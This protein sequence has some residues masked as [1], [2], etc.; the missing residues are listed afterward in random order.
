VEEAVVLQIVVR[1]I[2]VQQ[3][4]VPQIVVAR[5]FLLQTVVARSLSLTSWF[6]LGRQGQKIGTLMNPVYG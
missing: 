3:N 1:G 4:V 6:L 2:I 5:A